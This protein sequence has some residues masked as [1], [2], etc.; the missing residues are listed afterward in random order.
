ME[1]RVSKICLARKEENSLLEE[2]Y[3]AL[4]DTF[5][6][7]AVKLRDCLSTFLYFKYMYIV[8]NS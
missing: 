8:I 6:T 2:F 3:V 7:G 5:N 4:E 1:S